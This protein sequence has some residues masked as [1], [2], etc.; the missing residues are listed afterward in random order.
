[1]SVVSNNAFG[2]FTLAVFRAANIPVVADVM[3][4]PSLIV[5]NVYFPIRSAHLCLRLFNHCIVESKAYFIA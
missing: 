5:F 2:G 3:I 1:M 4:N